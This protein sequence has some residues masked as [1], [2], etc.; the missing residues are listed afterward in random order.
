MDDAG[1]DHRVPF[2]DRIVVGEH[3]VHR[4]APRVGPRHRPEA[5]RAIS[6][7]TGPADG[8]P[9]RAENRWRIGT[10]SGA[11]KRSGHRMYARRR[12]RTGRVVGVLL[13]LAGVAALIGACATLIPSWLGPGPSMGSP[14]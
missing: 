9:P 7:S 14:T 12:R 13:V 3:G 4:S 5:Y 1:A 2:R 8:R 6:G 10:V 11:M